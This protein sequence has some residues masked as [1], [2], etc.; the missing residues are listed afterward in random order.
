M[1]VRF[2]DLPVHVLAAVSLYSLVL[3]FVLPMKTM[4]IGSQ[5]ITIN[6]HYSICAFMS[7]DSCSDAVKYT[8]YN[9]ILVLSVT[10][11]LKLI[12][13]WFLNMFQ[14]LPQSNFTRAFI[15]CPGN[16]IN[17]ESYN[18]NSFSKHFKILKL[19]HWQRL[20]YGEY[21]IWTSISFGK[22][23]ND[24]KQKISWWWWKVNKKSIKIAFR[25]HNILGVFFNHKINPFVQLIIKKMWKYLYL[26]LRLF[27]HVLTLC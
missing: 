14:F 2:S 4:K 9:L 3:N 1:I 13:L 12:K 10:P 17:I 25:E 6:S 15:L 26:W 5:Q 23:F 24:G 22:I 8:Q 20:Q 21:C 16:W 11:S 19:P 7:C 18:W 27:V